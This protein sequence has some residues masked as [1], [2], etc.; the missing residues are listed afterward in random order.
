MKIVS[1][2]VNSVRMRLPH[3]LDWCKREKPDLLC[4]QE[5]KVVNEDF[6]HDAFKELGLTCHI[7]GQKS[8]NGVA[9]ITPHA[10]KNVRTGFLDGDLAD[11][12][13]VI[14]AEV[15]GVEVINVYVPQ[16]QEVGSEKFDLKRSFYNKLSE[17][18]TAEYDAAKPLVLTGDFNIAP[19]EK[20]VDDVKKRSGKCM[21]TE[22]EHGWLARLEAWGLQDSLR[23]KSDAEKV[24]S[25]WDYRAGA[26]EQNRGL[27]IDVMYMTKPMAARL[28]A[29][30]IHREER[31]K[32]QPSDHVPVVGV[33]E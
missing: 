18:L 21:F 25:W 15:N 27:R 11:Q 12:K 7:H 5:T 10:L 26:V 14:R 32:D 8:Y 22:E 23:L 19:S 1:W 4:L 16:G 13:R 3:I 29:T 33:F 2:N 31:L 17:L 9:L 28:L 20:D 30:E 24:F 6:P